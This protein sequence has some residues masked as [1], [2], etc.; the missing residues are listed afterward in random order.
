MSDS[1]TERAK[2]SL[3]G[4]VSSNV[5][6]SGQPIYFK[7]AEGCRMVDVDG[8]VYLDYTLA[9]GPM[10]LGHSPAVVLD[11]VQRA[12]QQGQLYAGQHEMEIELAEKIQ[13]IVPCAELVRFSNSGSEAVHAAVRLARAHTGREKILRFE[14]HYH[15][16]Y[17]DQLISVQPPVD[18]AGERSH[19]KPVLATAGQAYHVLDTTIVAAW[20]DADLLREVIERHAHELAAVVME[21]VMCNVGCIPPLPGYLAEVR[22]LCSAHGIVLIFDEVITGFRLGLG[23]AGLLW[24]HARPGDL[25]KALANGFSMSCLAG[26]REFMEHIATQ[27][28]NHSGTYNSN[29]MVTAAALAAL[30]ELEHSADEV[31]PR[32]HRLGGI[33]ANRTTRAGA[34]T[35]PERSH[36][37]NWPGF[38]S[39]VHQP[40]CHHGLSQFPC[41]GSLNLACGLHL[42]CWKEVSAF[43][44]ADCGICRQRTLK[45]TSPSHWR[46]SGTCGQ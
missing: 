40:D 27:Q 32:L 2:R 45:K 30:S 11:A 31:Y 17:D 3:A 14:G 42:L 5:R 25:A 39:R 9:Q 7:H 29:V 41:I 16:W 43:C 23:G 6:A 38:S 20:N 28:V 12:M 36:S 13:S 44:R 33:L 26:R 24:R 22:A 1:L 8:N 35:W 10:L 46:R 15:G 34:R 4:G 19:P 37:G 18:K 21:P